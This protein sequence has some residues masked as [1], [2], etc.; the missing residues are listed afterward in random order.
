MH[1][2]VKREN[3]TRLFGVNIK[4]RQNFNYKKRAKLQALT[5]ISEYMDVN[6]R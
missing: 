6:K 2:R 1:L 4:G 3:R 5:R